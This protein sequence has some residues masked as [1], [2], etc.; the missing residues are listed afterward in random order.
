M[1]RGGSRPSTF[2]RELLIEHGLQ[3]KRSGD[4]LVFGRSASE[5]F[6]PSHIRR[7]A[8]AAWKAYNAELAEQMRPASEQL[9][10]IGLHEC[11]P[12]T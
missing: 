12:P 11:R 1:Q 5:P 4:D 10:P 6:T 7:Q 8:E 3:T 9:R 2:L